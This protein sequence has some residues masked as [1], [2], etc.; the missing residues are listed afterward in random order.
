MYEH[1]LK[2][3]FPIILIAIFWLG[4][5]AA[6][7]ALP[8]IFG[9]P[10]GGIVSTVHGQPVEADTLRVTLGGMTRFTVAKK[11]E[12]RNKKGELDEL[13]LSLSSRERGVVERH[14]QAFDATFMFNETRGKG[15][16]GHIYLKIRKG[17]IVRVQP[18]RT[19]G[20]IPDYWINLPPGGRFSITLFAHE[21]D[22][23]KDNSCK[24]GNKGHYS[25]EMSLPPIPAPVP[26]SCGPSN[27][28][29]WGQLDAR[30]QVFGMRDV[31]ITEKGS[32]RLYPVQGTV[33]ITAAR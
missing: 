21:S 3:H 28:F 17:D 22:C 11:G 9:V 19:G 16:N 20:S 29:R 27:T 31:A 15:N 26:T 7:P 8:D 30:Y 18:H 6:S 24:R 32:V 12:R 1:R 4:L 25:V 13:I 10:R 2:M 33:C 14:E 5:L 23:L